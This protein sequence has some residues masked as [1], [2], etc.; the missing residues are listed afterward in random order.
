MEDHND[1]NQNPSNAGEGSG[2]LKD[3]LTPEQLASITN[4]QGEIDSEKASKLVHDF[5]K[6]YGRM[7][8]L[9]GQLLKKSKESKP[10]VNPPPSPTPH[11]SEGGDDTR[12]NDMEKKI[13]R[14]N[15]A[16]RG[17]AEEEIDFIMQSGGSQM[18][19]NEF[20]KAAIDSIRAKKKS[21]DS[22]PG[23]TNKSEVYQKYT[24]EQLATMSSSELMKIIPKSSQ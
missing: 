10:P 8:F 13:E 24:Q 15:L 22:T 9:E 23:S 17:Y 19:G 4:D 2:D 7:K 12:W 20:V 18:L 16:A 11:R 6:V 5:G 14:T 3:V 21:E 1:G